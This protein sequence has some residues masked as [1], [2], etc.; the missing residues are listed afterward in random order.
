MENQKI[1]HFI[2]HNTPYQYFNL[3]APIRL[4]TIHLLFTY[5]SSVQ[6]LTDFLVHVVNT[7]LILI[8]L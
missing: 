5:H 2:I 3:S 1:Y 8:W 4:L 7:I 6:F